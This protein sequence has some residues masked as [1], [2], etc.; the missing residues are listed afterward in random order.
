MHTVYYFYIFKYN[1]LILK[2]SYLNKLIDN[3]W[4][5][6]LIYPYFITNFMCSFLKYKSESTYLSPFN[7]KHLNLTFMT[8]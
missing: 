3:K 5:I 1:K 8:Y 4:F 2:C 6:L 7:T